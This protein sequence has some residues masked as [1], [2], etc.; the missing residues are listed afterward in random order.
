METKMQPF[1][2]NFLPDHLTMLKK[3]AADNNRTV[4]FMIR[5]FVEDSLRN[6]PSHCEKPTCT[7][8]NINTAAHYANHSLKPSAKDFG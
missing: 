1:S 6:F 8:S 4:G 7:G 3:I 5:R 2:V